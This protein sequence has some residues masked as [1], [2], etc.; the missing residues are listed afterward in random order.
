[1]FIRLK[2]P[3]ENRCSFYH[4][5]RIYRTALYRAVLLSLSIGSLSQAATA[6]EAEPE[7]KETIA[8]K[9]TKIFSTSPSPDANRVN[10]SVIS[11]FKTDIK[12]VD[13]LPTIYVQAVPDSKAAPA[14]SGFSLLEIIKIAVLRNPSIGGSL[15][16]LAQQNTQVDL[17]KSAYWPQVRA[18]IGTGRLGTGEAKQQLLTVSASQVL[19]DFGK[20]KSSVVSSE[21][22]VNQQKAIVLGTIDDVAKQTAVAV[23]NVRRYQELSRLAER[24]LAGVE[25]I[26]K[27]AR[28]RANAGLTSQADPIQAQ[29]RFEG[30]QSILLQNKTS[31][32]Q[33]EDQLRSLTGLVPPYDVIELPQ[34]L[35]ADA[36][37]YDNPDPNTLPD[38]IAAEY[39][40]QSAVAQKEL[41]KANRLPTVTLEGSVNQAING[42]NPNNNKDDGT[43]SS[44]MLQLNSAAWQ[45][46][47]LSARE[48]AANYAEQAARAKI[49]AAYLDASTQ[50]NSFREQVFGTQQRLSVLA[51]RER[52]IIKTR[53]LYEDQYKLGTRTILD[54]LNSEQEIHLAASDQENARY[55]IWQNI[56]NYVAVTG[57]TRDVYSLNNITIQGLE[58]QP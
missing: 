24:Q 21:A 10:T 8:E 27:I 32:R 26:L 35:I 40:R 23:V 46:G 30:A 39:E 47:S 29:T 58:I 42:R 1:L 50:I 28:L 16:G 25:R 20:I 12:N 14:S 55:D 54:L 22:S 37:L 4:T 11:D 51:N 33:W 57:R 6:N 38:V 7:S 19:Y 53:E 36:K 45:G 15:A 31:L 2:T 56:V 5:K 41:S 9:L 43:Y 49:E 34:S 18:G 13:V 52:S 3:Y 48:R 17:A 44:L